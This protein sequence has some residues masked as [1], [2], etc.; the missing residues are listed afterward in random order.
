MVIVSLVVFIPLITS[1][2]A[3]EIF[4][5]SWTVFIMPPVDLHPHQCL[6]RFASPFQ[7]KTSSKPE[8]KSRAR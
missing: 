1:V 4:G 7:L 3:I 2:N 5:L 6:Y 8:A